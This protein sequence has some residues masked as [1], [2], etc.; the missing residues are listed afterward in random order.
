MYTPQP[1]TEGDTY[2]LGYQTT[3]YG[4]GIVGHSGASR[5]WR[6]FFSAAPAERQ[7]NVLL[8]NGDKGR[9][10]YKAILA[11]LKGAGAQYIE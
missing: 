1:N 10:V 5:G 8:T 7:G 11:E 6:T 9:E 3:V 4:A 2:G